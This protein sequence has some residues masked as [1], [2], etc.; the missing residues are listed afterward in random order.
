MNSPDLLVI[1]VT[2]FIAVFTLLAALAVIMRIT[3]WIFAH[4]ESTADTAMLA[5]VAAAVSAVY[6]GTIITKVE[7]VK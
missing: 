1:C 2:A 6:P 3:S 7:E 5:A 4:K